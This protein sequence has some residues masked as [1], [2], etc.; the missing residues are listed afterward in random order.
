MLLARDIF[1]ERRNDDS[2]KSSFLLYKRQA[3][4][5][6]S[7]W[8]GLLRPLLAGFAFC[9]SASAAYASDTATWVNNVY[10]PDSWLD[11]IAW[12]SEG[13]ISNTPDNVAIFTNQ[14]VQNIYINKSPLGVTIKTIKF[15]EN[16][17]EFT[18][19]VGRAIGTSFEISGDGIV[20]AGAYAPKFIVDGGEVNE[21]IH[22]G[23]CFTNKASAGNAA[24]SAL[25]NSRI[26]FAN[27]ATAGDATLQM[28]KDS[29][30]DFSDSASAGKAK[31]VLEGGSAANF[32]GSATG[33]Q[34]NITAQSGSKINFADNAKAGSA[35]LQMEKDSALNFAGSSSAG[36]AKIALQSGSAANFSDT[37]DGGQAEIS[38]EDGSALNING[39]SNGGMGIGSV[40]GSGAINLGDKTLSIGGKNKDS[41]FGGAI[42]GAGGLEKTGSGALSLTKD[43]DFTGGV[44][45]KGGIVAAQSSKA[46]GSGDVS[47]AN[48]GRLHF[49]VSG[50][51]ANAIKV[52]AGASGAISAANGVEAA[53]K[54]ITVGDG[55]KLAFGKEGD[56][57]SGGAIAVSG[58]GSN[59]DKNT[60]ISVNS[61][62]LKLSDAEAGK[63]FEAEGSAFNVG[64]KGK[65]DV[66]GFDLN[67]NKLAGS[68]SVTTGASG[69]VMI[70]AKEGS[71]SGKISDGAGK[72]GLR[73]TGAGALTVSGDQ[74]Y[75]GD[76]DLQE[77]ELRLNGNLQKSNVSM[78]EGGAL[79]ISGAAS[80]AAIG[81]LS[82]SGGAITLGGKKLSVGGNNKDSNFGGKISGGGALETAGSGTFTFNGAGSS[83]D[84]N[85]DILVGSGTLKLGDA[86]A[87]KMMDIEGSAFNIDA[88]GKVDMNGFDLNVN[89]L[90]GSG[91]I[92]TGASGDV[93]ISV[94]EGNFNGKISDGAG[95][96]GI[97]KTGSGLF[98]LGGDQD[99]SGKTQVQ[100][101]E[102]RIDGNLKK[103]DVSVDK[104]AV[105]SGSGRI[106]DLHAKEGSVISAGSN[107]A[108]GSGGGDNCRLTVE[109]NSIFDKGSKLEVGPK[110]LCKNGQVF[111]NG[112]ADIRGGDV[113]TKGFLHP[114][115]SFKDVVSASG[116]LTGGFD[117]IE[118][119][120]TTA[121][122][123]PE[124]EQSAKGVNVLVLRN[125][126]TLDSVGRSGNERKLGGG[127]ETL[128]LTNDLMIRVLNSTKAQAQEGLKQLSGQVY[129]STGSAIMQG[130]GAL[131]GLMNDRMS[132]G[133]QAS[134][135]NGGA[136]GAAQSFGYPAFGSAAAAPAG[137]NAKGTILPSGDY[138]LGGRGAVWVRG[139]SS[140]QDSKKSGNGTYGH[141]MDTSGSFVGLDAP[142][143]KWLLGGAVGLG[144]SAFRNK[145]LPNYGH[146]RSIYSGLYAG[147]DYK[148]FNIRL[149]G[150]QNWH[151]IHTK[152]AV[153]FTRFSDYLKSK[154]HAQMTQI[155]AQ[156][157]RPFDMAKGQI[158]P[159]AGLSYNYLHNGKM[160]ERGGDAALS[161]KSGSY[162]YF[163]SILGA[164]GRMQFYD[165]DGR[166][167]AVRAML[168]WQHAYGSTVPAVKMSFA[169]SQ[170]FDTQGTPLARDAAAVESGMDFQFNQYAMLGLSYN[171]QYAKRN[172]SHGVR[173]NFRQ[174]Y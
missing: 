161:A 142:A 130:S 97:N 65:V 147:T 173:V 168:G 61:G 81:S 22:A 30:L 166:G 139:F 38:M 169:E 35:A 133:G 21:F 68:G 87:G 52:G 41:N 111:I 78:K 151:N 132:G 94:K 158:E 148:S 40:N 92:T 8:G 113:A 42:S 135:D 5:A 76:T 159:F 4:R 170:S 165:A 55:G 105:L 154:Y 96:L 23:L 59:I 116:T 79:N 70:G 120:Y 54:N 48:D 27:N 51:Y 146:M 50:D 103:L 9:L 69:D 171:G 43:N 20:N 26:C 75:S 131:S 153:E 53:P 150:Q 84:K 10:N 85:T 83:I 91:A 56:N 141:E 66:N 82:G 88:K 15:L 119:E 136:G 77:G 44:A 99:Y 126:V 123:K 12:R 98:V 60:A 164:R 118:P 34:A 3:Q 67:V 134:A 17:K 93:M 2:G 25:S 47:L 114:G 86:E 129:A 28:N 31:A 144:Y 29:T 145:E 100:E 63:M 101:G 32:T 71:F 62:T 162:D 80:G 36:S 90:T 106:K 121:F 74:D 128:P 13:L 112:D 37:A 109:G 140:W 33:G 143:G 6:P 172:I 138:A 117:S 11:P 122:I 127:M 155:F 39:L 163:G 49:G 115:E 45:I 73:K 1:A 110:G 125:G 160:K 104:N 102:L 108:S 16:A 89:R 58:A 14:G 107:S 72:I 95:K 18:F 149:G 24:I 152:R 64:A 19:N 156:M 157:G 57:N 46:L 137:K 174:Q 124:F 7:A 167:A